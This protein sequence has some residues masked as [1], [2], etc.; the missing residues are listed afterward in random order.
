ML[1]TSVLLLVENHMQEA[2]YILLL[3]M[4]LEPLQVP[5]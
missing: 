5:L 4:P 1:L 2:A 3:S